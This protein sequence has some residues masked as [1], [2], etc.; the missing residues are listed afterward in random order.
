MIENVRSWHI[1][2]EDLGTLNLGPDR[3]IAG[4][5]WSNEF[6]VRE[7]RTVGINAMSVRITILI[8]L[9]IIMMGH[10][11]GALGAKCALLDEI[12]W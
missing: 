4:S 11:L 1:A 3:I 10:V 7:I 9:A 5:T 2:V 8:L 12:V 6:M